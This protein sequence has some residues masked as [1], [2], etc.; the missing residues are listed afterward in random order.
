V[1]EIISAKN[2]RQLAAEWIAQGIR[3]AGPQHAGGRVLYLPLENPADL[4]LDGFIH[5]A[6]SAKEFLF[7]KTETLYGYRIEG[8]DVKLV[9][10][11]ETETAQVLLAV[12]PCDAAA[13]PILDHIFNWDCADDP[14]NRRRQN[15]TIVALAC[16]AHD[17]NCFCTSVGLGPASER[18]AD[19]LLIPLTNDTFEVRSITDKGRALFA[20]KTETDNVAAMA[21]A[22]PEPRFAPEAVRKF[23]AANFEHPLWA[24]HALA[25]VGCGA[26]AHVCPTC[27]CFDIVD[28]HSSRVRNWDSCQFSLFTLHASGHNPRP[29]QGSRQR[30]RILHKFSIYPGK[31]GEILCTGCGNCT[32]N[33]PAG[34]GV[35]PLLIVIEHEEHLP[36]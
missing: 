9:E 4:L 24:E 30:Q 20:G 2:L 23:V 28:E 33:C 27:H 13:F 22:G 3:V 18:G 34:L 32:R 35:L 36:A 10:G 26:C 19:A 14:Y 29:D 7:P 5:P 21:A 15:T 12:R 8:N 31:F 11:S 16:S 17:A 1:S 25:C 6:N